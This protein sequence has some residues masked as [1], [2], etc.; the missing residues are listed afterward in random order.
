M[1]ASVRRA[2]GAAQEILPFLDRLQAVAEHRQRT[3]SVIVLLIQL[4][5]ARGQAHDELAALHALERAVRL[6]E[7]GGYTR[8][9]LDEG[10][11]MSGLLR[12]LRNH[13]IGAAYVARLLAIFDSGRNRP[14]PH[15]DLLTPREREVLNLLALG[16]PNRAIAEHLV[17]SEATVKSHVH[18]LI[19]KLGVRNRAQVPVR[20]R[21][22]GVLEPVTRSAVGG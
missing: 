9:F 7:P 14:S 13:S 21:A 1:L 5:L 18:H 3:G 19:D 10:E 2:Q 12:R 15:V 8:V 20:A 22:L 11:L 4:A 6:A 16:L 17:T